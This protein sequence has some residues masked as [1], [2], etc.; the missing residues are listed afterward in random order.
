MTDK[1]LRDIAALPEFIVTDIISTNLTHSQNCFVWFSL[2]KNF[3]MF[4]LISL[5]GVAN[6]GV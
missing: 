4:I 2:F 5:G 3:V 6:G 1:V